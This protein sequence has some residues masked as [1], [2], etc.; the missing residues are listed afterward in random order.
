M[1]RKTI[2]A[3]AAIAALG[4]AALA[5]TS[6]SAFGHGG[7]GHGG[8]GHFGGGHFGGGHMMSRGPIGHHQTFNRIGHG[9]RGP[10]FARFDRGRGHH[11]CHFNHCGPRIGWWWR[12]H[13]HPYWVYPVGGE[14]AVE[15][16]GAA[17]PA[18]SAP[19]ASNT[20]TCLTKSYLPDGSVM[21]KDVCT[22]E[23]AVATPDELKAQAAG[24]PPAAETK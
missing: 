4:I 24:V 8:G 16:E 23:A 17:A 20:C 18:Y 6:A 21:F 5:P 15:T 13:H 14:A 12:H 3:L 10:H 9:P 7:G 22:K 19:A 1:S 11:F 2:L